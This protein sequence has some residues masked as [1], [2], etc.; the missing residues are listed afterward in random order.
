[1]KTT[2]PD[3]AVYVS[4]YMGPV[5]GSGYD[6][7]ISDN[8]NSNFYSFAMIGS[9][10]QLPPFLIQNYLSAQSFLA[11]SYYFKTVQVEVFLVDGNLLMSL[12]LIV[13]FNTNLKLLSS[14]FI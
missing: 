6:L 10:Y 1:M 9:S 7:A 14:H 5:F 11:G 13:K 4:D 2:N 8:S 3:S 12:R